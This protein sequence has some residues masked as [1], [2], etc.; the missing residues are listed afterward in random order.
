[1]E[2]NNKSPQNCLTSHT[3]LIPS[4]THPINPF[5]LPHYVT[6]SGSHPIQTLQ[7][8]GSPNSPALKHTHRFTVLPST[9]L[10]LC[11]IACDGTKNVRRERLRS[12]HLGLAS[13]RACIH[14]Y[15]RV[16]LCI[17]TCV[18]LIEHPGKEG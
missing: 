11:N 3:L 14:P 13:Y 8:P 1:M 4:P 7:T 12:E 16:R 15:M 5:I 10:M 18:T 17:C 6:P 2:G 9:P